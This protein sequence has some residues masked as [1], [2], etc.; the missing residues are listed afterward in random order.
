MVEQLHCYWRW[1]VSDLDAF[2]V[3][4]VPSDIGFVDVDIL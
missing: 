2:V 3:V 4:D 1:V